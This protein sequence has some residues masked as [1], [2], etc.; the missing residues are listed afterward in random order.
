[1]VTKKFSPLFMFY[2]LNNFSCLSPFRSACS[3]VLREMLFGS[4]KEK[5][6]KNLNFSA[7]CLGHKKE[8]KSCEEDTKKHPKMKDGKLNIQERKVV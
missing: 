7:F 5:K 6:R 2:K 3:S 8:G 4:V 1:M